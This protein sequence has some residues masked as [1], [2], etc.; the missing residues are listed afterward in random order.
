MCGLVVIVPLCSDNSDLLLCQSGYS[1]GIFYMT[2]TSRGENIS[3]DLVCCLICVVL[4]YFGETI[5]SATSVA[6]TFLLLNF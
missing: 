1:H 2:K 3:V 4:E 5:N 6:G